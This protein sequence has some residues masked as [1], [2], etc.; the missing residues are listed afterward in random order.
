METMTTPVATGRARRSQATP[1]SGS[2][3]RTPLSTPRTTLTP[4]DDAA[5][6]AN[7]RKRRQ[8]ERMRKSLAGTF[9]AT[10]A[11]AAAAGAE[12]LSESEL[13]LM[14][15][16][17]LK[18]A[19]ENKI[20]DRNVWSLPL[21]DHLPD[22]VQRAAPPPAGG[23]GGE[24]EGGGGGGNYFTRI[25]GGLDAGVQIYARRVDATWKLAYSQLHGA[26]QIDASG[27]QDADGSQDAGAAAGDAKRRRRG[28][29]EPREDDT[30]ADAASLRAR[31]GDSSFMVDPLFHRMS[32]I[33]D[34]DGAAGMLLLNHSVCNGSTIMFEHGGVPEDHFP[35]PGAAGA[36][37]Q[38]GDGAQEDAAVNMA[39]LRPLLQSLQQQQ[40]AAAAAGAAPGA[41]GA[42]APAMRGLHALLCSQGLA[43]EVDEAEVEEEVAAVMAA[44]EGDCAR[45]AAAFRARVPPTA[46]A[47]GASGA[48]SGSAADGPGGGDASM[49]DADSGGAADGM[50]EMSFGGVAG[51]GGADEADAESAAA[52]AAR[53]AE[54]ER[55][56][57]E[58]GA[59]LAEQYTQ[60]SGGGGGFDGDDGYGD[61]GGGWDAGG[62]DGGSD[63]E[64]GGAGAGAAGATPET[65]HAFMGL[66]GAEGMEGVLGED[67]LQLLLGAGAGGGVTRGTGWA[68][69]SYWRFSRA[70]GGGRPAGAAGK[71]AEG[72]A[73]ARRGRRAAETFVDFEAP[74]PIPPDALAPGTLKQTTL[75]TC[76]PAATLLPEDLRYEA[77]ALGR[78]FLKP[79]A[80]VVAPPRGGGGADTQRRAGGGGDQWAADMSALDDAAPG[81]DGGGGDDDDDYG[82]D[83]GG[84]FGD[85]GGGGDYD[86]GGEG[87]G[88]GWGG[89]G[90][91]AAADP[92][93]QLLQAPRRAAHFGVS[94]SR[95]SKQVDVHALK[96]IIW[97]GVLAA[98]GGAAAADS[99]AAAGS[100]A[101]DTAARPVDFHDVIKAVPQESAA[102][103]LEDMS[104]H[105]CFICLL[106]LA[107]QH[108]LEVRSGDDL[109]TLTI[110]GAGAR[111]A[112]AA[113]KGA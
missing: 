56:E 63:A 17:A 42:V 77:A 101:A 47:A 55:E 85:Y 6:K 76:A 112:G 67:S 29:A 5:E 52:A 27:S 87:E 9:D 95:A 12:C 45:L 33:F 65:G 36:R 2:A 59:R 99:S 3:K 40:R 100:S 110:A 108:G 92:E 74:P 105:M 23:G 89:G 30:L 79:A 49:A 94:Y 18:L 48:L 24:G 53:L 60:Y 104:V 32:Q 82:D 46:R 20:N 72:G 91:D 58:A 50:D 25:S 64:G 7:A 54:E 109:R 69:S 83:A 98:D 38:E 70:P 113:A 15:D 93:L 84:G 13:R 68:G 71:A 26:P 8:A 1:L 51:A 14:L 88:D 62:D 75:A 86:S 73:K 22:M 10:A 37:P 21:I 44:V 34:E 57:A 66:L 41:C 111:T 78:L 81:Y 31:Q 28:G 39:A 96:E 4:N 35:L 103:R 80:V 102:G 43:P 61:D 19:A 106:H 90:E 16:M 97:G 11:G 107:N